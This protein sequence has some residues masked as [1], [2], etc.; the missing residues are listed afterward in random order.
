MRTRITH[1]VLVLVGLLIALYPVTLG[2]SA[3]ITCRGVAMRPGDT[4][5][6]SD[7]TGEKNYQ[8][9]LA[10]RR[11]AAPVVVIIGLL[12]AGFG[13]TLLVSEL[14]GSSDRR[15]PGRPRTG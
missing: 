6:K 15:R 2:A 14:R 3:E 4:C 13:A 12:V 1:A 11:G 9:R 8:Q 7:G 5:L 10:A